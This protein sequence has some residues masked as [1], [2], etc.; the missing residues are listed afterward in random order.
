MTLGPKFFSCN[1]MTITR[2]TKHL[3]F[4]KE[5][6]RKA[7]D[8]YYAVAL[9]KHDLKHSGICSEHLNA[10]LDSQ[11]VFLRSFTPEGD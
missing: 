5:L 2:R 9:S 3:R 6:P 10:S 1:K 8:V 4:F 11:A 7:L